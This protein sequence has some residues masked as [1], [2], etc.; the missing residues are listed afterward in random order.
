MRYENPLKILEIMRLLEE[1]GLSHREIA[2]SVNCGK[3]TVSEIKRRCR[4][5]GLTYKEAQSMSYTEI[6]DA[7]YPKLAQLKLK[8]DPD[9][10][11]IHARLEKHPR[12]NLQFIWTEEY[13]P[14]NSDGFAGAMP[15]GAISLA[16]RL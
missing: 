2:S 15:N 13:R 5:A 12:L 8:A 3:T 10:P 1:Q 16:I 9:W 4:E 6:K 14:S 11:D 7:L